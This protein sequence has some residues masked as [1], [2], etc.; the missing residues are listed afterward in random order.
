MIQKDK[1]IA[2]PV[3]ST[4]LRV[5]SMGFGCAPLGGTMGEPITD[6]KA[7]TVVQAALRQGIRLF[8]TAPSYGHG[9]SEQ[10]LGTALQGIP[11][12]QF[13]LETK[14]GLVRDHKVQRFGL[15]V[16]SVRR[17][18]EESLVRLGLDFVD[19]LLIH[20]AD[21]NYREALD[22]VYPELESLR[23]EGV[24][25]AI[26]AGMN[27]WQMLADFARNGDF[28]VF[29]LAHRYTLLEQT[30][31]DFLN[32]CYQKGI[33]IHLA[34]VFHSGILATGA[35]QNAK[36]IYRDAPDDVCNRVSAIQNVASRYE[37]PLS[38]VALQFSWSHPAVTSLVVGMVTPEEVYDNLG[39][40]NFPIPPELW[41]DLR[42]E[43]LISDVAPL[44]GDPFLT[45]ES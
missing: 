9:L 19:I 45:H 6:E 31:I 16:G 43:G 29:M 1:N 36:F 12:D 35:V 11:R 28:D 15:P 40:F 23:S 24:I 8:D 13:V 34:G 33:S 39:A 5:S 41:S 27:Q 18:L 14:L 7:V 26:G 38:A 42:S 21:R 25:K 10:R 32:L 2:Y 4:S 44:P 20:D 22:V 37:V 3:G 17:C 30:S